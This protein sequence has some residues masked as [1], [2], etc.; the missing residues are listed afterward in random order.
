MSKL[1]MVNFKAMD[2]FRR[3][4]GFTAVRQKG[5]HVFYRHTDDRTTT[6]PN[7]GNRDFA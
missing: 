7:H 5:S 1:P 3:H 2:R 6:L 4:L